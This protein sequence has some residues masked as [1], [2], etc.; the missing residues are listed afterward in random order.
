MIAMI[1]AVVWVVIG[2]CGCCF[3]TWKYDE[4]CPVAVGGGGGGGVDNK[5]C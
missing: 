2:Q 3:R 1:E 4:I 5:D